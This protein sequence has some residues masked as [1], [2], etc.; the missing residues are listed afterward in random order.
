MNKQTCYNYISRS[1]FIGAGHRPCVFSIPYK[2]HT[3]WCFFYCR[4]KVKR[5]TEK[6]RRFCLAFAKSGN[7]TQ[8]AKDAG[9]SANSAGVTGPKLLKNKE[10]IAELQRITRDFNTKAVM[11]AEEIQEILTAIARGQETEE[12]IL[13]KG[14]GDGVQEIVHDRKTASAADKIKALQLLAR[15]QGVLDSSTTVNV[16]MPKFGGESDIDD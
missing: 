5:L 7:A 4:K 6:Q 3:K 9:Y 13:P 15:M 12:V 10:V 8:S 2:H 14:C 11:E 1:V 16:V